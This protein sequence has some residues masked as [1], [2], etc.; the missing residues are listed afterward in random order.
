MVRKTN[1]QNALIYKLVC[2]DVDVKDIYVGSTHVIFAAENRNI[3]I[4][5]TT[6]RMKTVALMDHKLITSLSYYE[7]K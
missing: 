1:Y 2:N 6:P 5:V 7:K 3:N 4:T